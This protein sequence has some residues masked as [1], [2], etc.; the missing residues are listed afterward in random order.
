MERF[1]TQ[2]NPLILCILR[3][4]NNC[5]K[6]RI[7]ILSR[8][9]FLRKILQNND[10]KNGERYDIANQAKHDTMFGL[11]VIGRK[12]SWKVLPASFE[13]VL[14]QELFDVTL[15][16]KNL[17]AC[18][19]VR[20]DSSRAVFPQGVSADFQRFGEFPVGDIPFAVQGRDAVF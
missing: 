1:S 17:I 15:F 12:D 10:S 11:P 8:N 9:L 7:F 6:G 19:I 14:I 3:M 4:S 18:G 5:C 2:L 20:N 16:V 13:T